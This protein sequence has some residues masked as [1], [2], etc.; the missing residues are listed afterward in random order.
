MCI[1]VIIKGF[2]F[3]NC[4]QFDVLKKREGVEGHNANHVYIHAFKHTLAIN[5]SIMVRYF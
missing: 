4:S 2:P 1:I 3:R 5:T